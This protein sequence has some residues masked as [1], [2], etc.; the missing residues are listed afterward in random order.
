VIR[1]T[2][3]QRLAIGNPTVNAL[4]KL[5]VVESASMLRKL[6]LYEPHIDR[7]ARL[8]VN[9]LIKIVIDHAPEKLPV[10][11]VNLYGFDRL[12]GRPIPVRKYAC[13]FGHLATVSVQL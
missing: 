7:K 13:A 3:A 2:Q 4:R 10:L 12:A 1:Q 9:A 11:F 5:A 6:F 8:H